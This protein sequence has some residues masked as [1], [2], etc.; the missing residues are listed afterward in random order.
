MSG[1]TIDLQDQL[2]S[3]ATETKSEAIIL[4]E[5]NGFI[6]GEYYREGAEKVS[7]LTQDFTQNLIIPFITTDFN[8]EVSEI[9]DRIIIELHSGF[10][11]FEPIRISDF[12]MY[13]I[14]FTISAEHA[15]EKFILQPIIDS[16]E[17]MKKIIEYFFH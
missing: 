14:R 16:S 17:K 4:L 1:Q 9:L 10:L 2:K 12:N 11:I 8:E 7:Q 5:S 3:F 15:I 13:V 6:I